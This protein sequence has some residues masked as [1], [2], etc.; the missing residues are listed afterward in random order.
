[1]PRPD[2][3]PVVES[4]SCGLKET[5]EPTALLIVPILRIITLQ[6]PPGFGT[7]ALLPAF[8]TEDLTGVPS[9]RV[10]SPVTSPFAKAGLGRLAWEEVASRHHCRAPDWD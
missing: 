1:M 4:A 6:G 10:V 2:A 5:R 9:N 3:L 7:G 8:G